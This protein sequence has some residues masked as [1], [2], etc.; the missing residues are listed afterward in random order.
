MTTYKDY[1][2]SLLLRVADRLLSVQQDVPSKV[3]G[4]TWD[5]YFPFHAEN[6]RSMKVSSEGN[7]NSFLTFLRFSYYRP[8]DINSMI[9]TMQ[10]ILRRTN[11]LASYVTA[12]NFDDPTFRDAHAE[13]LLGEIKDQLLFYYSHEEF[14]LFM[15]FFLHLRGKRKFSYSQFIESF[16]EFIVECQRSNKILPQFF[17]SADVF[18]QFLYEQNVIC[19]MEHDVSD[20]GDSDRFIRWCFRER[21]LS[22]MAPKI[23]ANVNYEI[24]YGLSKALNVG[25]QVRVGKKESRRLIGTVVRVRAEEGF[26]F[27]RGGDRHDDYYFKS[28]EFGSLDEKGIAISQKVS[29]EVSVK[30]GKPR[31]IRIKKIR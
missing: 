28:E 8:R 26:G 16:N 22:N 17:E 20:N 27:I 23:R 4:E 31:A 5:Y 24:F 29:F 1:R 25:R 19:Y 30:Y 3:V 12:D 18:L 10:D 6:V 13:Y 2:T 15:Q 9:N 14:D 7:V 11:P 21:T